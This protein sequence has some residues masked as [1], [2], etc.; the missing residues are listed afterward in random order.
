MQRFEVPSDHYAF[1]EILHEVLSPEIYIETGVA[2]GRT[3]AMAKGVGIGIDPFPN[4]TEP[5]GDRTQIFSVASDDF[6]EHTDLLRITGGQ[7]I[8]L[9]FVDGLHLF[10]NALRDF[11]N[12]EKYSAPGTVICIHDVIPQTVRMA[13]RE[14]QPDGWTGDVFGVILALREYRPDLFTVTID[15]PQTGMLL[16]SN[17]D[18]NSTTLHDSF[19]QICKLH[20]AFDY[21]KIHNDRSSIFGSVPYSSAIPEYLQ[22]RRQLLEA[23]DNVE[24]GRRLLQTDSRVRLG[25]R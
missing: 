10:E 13:S 15:L 2:S 9:G 25:F 3:L 17:L 16:V 11:I 4:I 18:P 6:F 12:F 8:D 19:E 5:L 21:A 14:P 23:A 1:L 22:A 24:R 7:R 20:L